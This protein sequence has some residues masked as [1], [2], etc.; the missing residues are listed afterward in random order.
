[1]TQEQYETLLGEL[2]NSLKKKDETI[3]LQGWQIEDLKAKLK[4]AE[5]H[6]N[7]TPKKAI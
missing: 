1:M 6:L 4:E 5:N 2:A 7:P 3:K